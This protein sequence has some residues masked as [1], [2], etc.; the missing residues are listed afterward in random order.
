MGKVINAGTIIIS[1]GL[2]A[3]VWL[4]GCDKLAGGTNISQGMDAVEQQ[5]YDAALGFFDRAVEADEDLRLAYRGKGIAY[6]GEGKYTE[7]VDAFDKALKSSNGIVKKVDYDINYYLAMAEFKNGDPDKAMEIYDAII[8][9]D[10]DAYEAYFLRGS[11]EL[12]RQDKAS[13][14]SDFDR[15]VELKEGDYDLYINIYE[16]LSSAGYDSDG[17]AYISRALEKNGKM[18]DYQSGLFSYYLGSYD[19]ARNSLEQAREK[20]ESEDLVLYLG[21]AYEALGDMNYAVSLY[22]DYLAEHPDSAAM[23]N[24]LGLVYLKQKD[25][26]NAL[27][28]FENGRALDNPSYSQNLM[29]NQVVAYEYLLDFDKA[30]GLMKEYLD[31]YPGDEAAQREYIFLSTR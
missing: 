2:T 16:A 12:N 10:E 22:S 19:D 14:L 29:F 24:E 25:Y 5:E 1:A 8:D 18:T 3:A 11:L 17:K 7:A 31:K 13:A 23:Y 4:G 15:A 20:G 27:S 9:L 28:S 6:M 21:K 26:E 30:S